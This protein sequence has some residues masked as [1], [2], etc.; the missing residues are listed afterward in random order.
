M[1][2]KI[3]RQ[4]NQN[5]TVY[6]Y[7]EYG[8]LIDY[9]PWYYGVVKGE[10]IK[11]LSDDIKENRYYNIVLKK[12]NKI[13]E[14]TQKILSN[15]RILVINIDIDNIVWNKKYKRI[16]AKDKYQFEIFDEYYNN[17]DDSYCCLDN[18]YDKIVLPDYMLSDE[19][20]DEDENDE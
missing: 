17:F 12:D 7:D 11:S 15:S 10:D 19:D 4:I 3:Y 13:N 20:D 14:N 9:K 5:K 16:E 1:K 8:H 2:I 18:F 6:V